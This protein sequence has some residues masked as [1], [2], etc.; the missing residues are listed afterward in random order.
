MGDSVVPSIWFFITAGEVSDEVGA[1]VPCGSLSA[2]IGSSL[3]GVATPDWFREV[4]R[5][6]IYVLASRCASRV[7]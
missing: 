4:L 1:L 5:D 7:T 6:R 2:V 3:I